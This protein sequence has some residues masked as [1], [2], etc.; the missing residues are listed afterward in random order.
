MKSLS[1]KQRGVLGGLALRGEAFDLPLELAGAGLE[2]RLLAGQRLGA[3]FKQ[4]LLAGQHGL[5]IRVRR[6]PHK[7]VRKLDPGQPEPLGLQPRL[8][9]DGAVILLG[10]NLQI[11]AGGGLVEADHDVA[12]RHPVALAD[13]DLADDAAGLVLH[14]LGVAL[15]HHIAGR[16][17]RPGERGRRRPRSHTA[18]QKHRYRQ[19]EQDVG[20]DAFTVSARG[21]TAFRQLER[22]DHVSTV[23]FRS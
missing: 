17:H 23:T 8:P 4:R 21:R 19:P 16:N 3:A 1:T 13:Q 15:D 5:H 14:L 9:R 18:N 10:Q 6:P 2:L 20:P 22:R 7:L 11:G 12:G